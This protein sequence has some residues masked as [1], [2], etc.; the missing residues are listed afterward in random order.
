MTIWN[1]WIVRKYVMG[2][3]LYYIIT[4]L[5]WGLGV[6]Y[7]KKIFTPTTLLVVVLELHL[8]PCISTPQNYTYRNLDECRIKRRFRIVFLNRFLF[9]FITYFITDWLDENIKKCGTIDLL[10]VRDFYDINS[11]FDNWCLPQFA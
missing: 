3:N 1:C 6:I 5:G 10:N 2:R 9:Y 11:L 7:F 4:W 8:L